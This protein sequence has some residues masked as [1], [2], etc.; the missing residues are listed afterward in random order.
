MQGCRAPGLGAQWWCPAPPA[1]RGAI[2][3]RGLT[4]IGFS[5]AQGSRPRGGQ[6]SEIA[7]P[8]NLAGCLEAVLSFACVHAHTHALSSVSS[9]ET[10]HLS[11]GLAEP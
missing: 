1:G 5:G 3:G 6:S 11:P 9:C 4:G 7:G 10:T 2:L 8:G